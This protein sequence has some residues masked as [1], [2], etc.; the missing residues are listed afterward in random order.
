MLP[1]Q[2]IGCIFPGHIPRFGDQ[3]YDAYPLTAPVAS[4][5]ALALLEW[6]LCD[7]LI[8]PLLRR[9]LLIKNG[10]HVLRE[11]AAQVQRP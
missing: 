11:L 9:L 6:V 3:S 5:N 7:S 2:G 8:A 10:I 1:G 4:G